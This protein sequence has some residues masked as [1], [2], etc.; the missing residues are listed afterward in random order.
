MVL[1]LALWQQW[2]YTN[3]V[4]FYRTIKTI[5]SLSSYRKILLGSDWPFMSL[6]VSQKKWV[7]IFR[8]PPDEVKEAGIELRQREIDAILGGN[9]ARVLNIVS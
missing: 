7:D 3:P 1:D 5:I 4:E 8:N 9:A 6:L 2:A